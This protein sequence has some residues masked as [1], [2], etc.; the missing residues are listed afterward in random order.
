MDF[1]RKLLALSSR[2]T[3]V[4][5]SSTTSNV[6]VISTTALATAGLIAFARVTL[7]PSKVKVLD[8]PLKNVIPHMSKEKLKELVYQPDAFP[9]ARDVDTPVSRCWC[10]VGTIRAWRAF[11]NVI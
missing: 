3:D 5:N 8:N 9:G 1:V 10:R 6:L 7:W 11:K 2:G 4:N